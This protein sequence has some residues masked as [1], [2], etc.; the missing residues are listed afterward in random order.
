M[1]MHYSNVRRMEKWT[2]G[3]FYEPMG[4]LLEKPVKRPLNLN[5]CI[6]ELVDPKTPKGLRIGVIHQ[7]K[8]RA[9][10]WEEKTMI[11]IYLVRHGNKKSGIGD[12]GLT[13][14][15]IEQAQLTAQHFK[16]GLFLHVYS[17]PL[18][19]ARETASYIAAAM[20][21]PVVVDD[22][23]RERA[24]WGDL[25]EQTFE[26]FVALW[27]RCSQNRHWLPPAGDSAVQ[28]GR[29][30]ESFIRA[31]SQ[32]ETTPSVL[33]VAHGGVITDFLLN[34][35]PL[36]ILQAFHP[37]FEAAQ[38]QLIPECSTTQ[39]VYHAGQYA[40]KT[41]GDARHLQPRSP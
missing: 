28:S 5:S 18:M 29:R 31:V 10:R 30:I 14:Q 37:A 24:N 12:V 4:S 35:I 27:N 9:V 17:S 8:S 2:D 13:A 36:E 38:S 1:A 20:G 22:R 19:R 33:A 11:T 16:T 15:G 39:I 34:V 7:E 41:L 25:P 32:T 6:F 21:V 26:D 40:L 23:L 3:L